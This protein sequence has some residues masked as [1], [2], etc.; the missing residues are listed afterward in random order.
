MLAGDTGGLSWLNYGQTFGLSEAGR[1]ESWHSRYYIRTY[2]QNYGCQHHRH[3]SCNYYLSLLV[4]TDLYVK[5]ILIY[6]G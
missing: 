1:A 3:G 6:K 2:D 5:V 4:I